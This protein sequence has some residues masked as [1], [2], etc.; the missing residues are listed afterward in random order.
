MNRTGRNDIEFARRPAG[1]PRTSDRGRT[2]RLAGPGVLFPDERAGGT[3]AYRLDFHTLDERRTQPGA[4]LAFQPDGQ[5]P[6][7]LRVRLD[8]RQGHHNQPPPGTG[9]RR[10]YRYDGP[11]GADELYI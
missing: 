1:D 10:Q 6:V 3:A 4:L 5:Q 9:V 2:R 11:A 8:R 7:L